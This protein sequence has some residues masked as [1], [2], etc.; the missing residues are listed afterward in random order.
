M[1]FNIICRIPKDEAFIEKYKWIAKPNDEKDNFF[2]LGVGDIIINGEV[3]EDIDEYKSGSRSSDILAKYKQ[4]QGCM[5]IEEVGIN[6]DGGRCNE[7]YFV[8]GI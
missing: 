4:L 2:T 3:T 5:I 8:K 7:H 6:I 1:N